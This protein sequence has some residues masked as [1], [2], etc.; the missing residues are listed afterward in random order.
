VIK[1]PSANSGTITGTRKNITLQNVLWAEGSR[2]PAFPNTQKIWKVAFVLLTKNAAASQNLIQ[3]VAK[4]RRAFNWEVY[5]GTRFLGK[6]DTTLA[7]TTVFP[8]VQ[9][10]AVATDNDRAIVGWQTSATTKGRVNY[11]TSPATFDRERAHADGFSTGLENVFGTSHGVLLT[12]LTPNSTY[13]FEVVVETQ[14]GQIDR[15]GPLPMYTRKTNDAAPPDINNVSVQVIGKTVFV[16]WKTDERCDSRVRYGT[17][18]PP[19]LSRTDPYPTTDHSIVLSNLTSGTYNISVASQDAAGNLTMDDNGGAYFKAVVPVSAAPG[20][21]GAKVRDVAKELSAINSSIDEGDEPA[22]METLSQLVAKVSEQELRYVFATAELPD[23]PLEA[24]FEAL[25]GLATRLGGALEAT[26]ANGEYVDFT[27]VQ[28][29]LVSFTCIKLAPEMVAQV[30]LS[31]VSD[32]IEKV[33]PGVA[34][35][36][37]PGLRANE[38]RLRR[39]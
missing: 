11:A 13:Y 1:N 33:Y 31:A 21:G 32:A 22:A 16:K 37:H 8:S 30:G 5:K 29:P 27:A 7:A 18:S 3:Q 10:V 28:N 20:L 6:V 24:A 35:E 19:L 15:V 26:E 25:S 38:Y 34:L 36:P 2:N 23:D 9:S 17:T 12:G 4:Q 39:A 14:P